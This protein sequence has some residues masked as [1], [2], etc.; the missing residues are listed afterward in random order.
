MGAEVVNGLGRG[1]SVRGWTAQ[2]G[3]GRALSG[4]AKAA[5]R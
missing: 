4:T 2:E 5:S 3:Y 1:L